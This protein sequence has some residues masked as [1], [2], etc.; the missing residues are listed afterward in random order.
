M[1]SNDPNFENGTLCQGDNLDFLRSMNS[2]Y[3][4]PIA[5]DP[6]FNQGQ[7][8]YATPESLKGSPAPAGMDHGRLGRASHDLQK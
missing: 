4:H 8:L 6:P 5:M 2:R 3:V 1:Q 7:N